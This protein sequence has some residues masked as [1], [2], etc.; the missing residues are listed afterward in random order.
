MKF[1]L[2]ILFHLLFVTPLWCDEEPFEEDEEEWVVNCFGNA[3]DPSEDVTF[4]QNLATLGSEPSSIVNGCVNVLNGTFIES[5]C[6]LMSPGPRP[7][8]VQ[9]LYTSSS[10]WWINEPE[11]VRIPSKKHPKIVTHSYRGMYTS[12]SDLDAEKYDYRVRH[13]NYR[14]GLTNSATGYI[15]GKNN[16]H[17]MAMVIRPHEMREDK[18]R[19]TV[20]DGTGIVKKFETPLIRKSKE[21]G[22]KVYAGSAL[23]YEQP[24]RGPRTSYT[25]LYGPRGWA[26][27]EVKAP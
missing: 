15:G 2:L 13:T 21:A 24:S 10:G 16:S 5:G 9:H 26:I 17:N 18:L 27:E 20:C 8:M 11:K 19:A 22:S 12:F 6:N 23:T 14:R 1:K 7:L 25:Y 3:E 4:E